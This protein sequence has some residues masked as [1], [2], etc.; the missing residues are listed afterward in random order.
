MV[1]CGEVVARAHIH[2]IDLLRLDRTVEVVVA[3]DTK[4]EKRPLVREELHIRRVKTR[5]EDVV[6][7]SDIDL[8]LITTPML[9]HGPI[10][11]AALEPG[12]HVLIEKPMAVTLSEAARPVQLAEPSPASPTRVFHRS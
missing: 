10:A 3:C 9:E 1:G 4:E 12:K 6:Q 2:S 8:V 5:F 7:D 11:T